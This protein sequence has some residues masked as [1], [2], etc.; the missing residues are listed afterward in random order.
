MDH[1]ESPI[2]NISEVVKKLKE[3]I[4]NPQPSTEKKFFPYLES[5]RNSYNGDSLSL[6]KSI[7]TRNTFFHKGT[8]KFR[9]AYF[10]TKR[11][12]S[13]IEEKIP[14]PTKSVIKSKKIPQ[15]KSFK[16]LLKKI[17][18]EPI[19]KIEPVSASKESIRLKTFQ[20]KSIAKSTPTRFKT[21]IE[22]KSISPEILKIS[23][24]RYFTKSEL[25][26]SSSVY[27]NRLIRKL[28]MIKAQHFN[29]GINLTH[30]VEISC[31]DKDSFLNFHT[32][33]NL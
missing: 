30:D 20:N 23:K 28:K 19:Q 6:R 31:I 22:C 24:I 15:K 18:V 2:V 7:Y 9:E 4:P 1:H 33:E 26:N 32:E 10:S 13:K 5:Y 29:T 16:T 25:Q 14:A 17:H 12:F 27:K 8:L 11:L 3:Y 21:K